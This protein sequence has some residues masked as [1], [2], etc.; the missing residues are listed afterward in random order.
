MFDR[1]TF[2]GNT[3]FNQV[4]FSKNAMFDRATFSGGADFDRATFS[5]NARFDQA[6]FS[7]PARFNDV[8]FSGDATFDIVTFTNDARFNRAIFS[9]NVR[10]D[11][12]TFTGDATFVQA[13]FASDSRFYRATFSGK[14]RFNKASFTGNTRFD[15]VTFINDA[16]FGQTTFSGNATF[17]QATFGRL[18]VFSDAKFE[19]ARQF[20]PLLAYRGLILD[21]AEF[22]EPVQIEVSS[23]AVRCR[24]ARFPH[25]VQFGL[26]W[27]QVVLEE[28]DFPAPSILTGIPRLSTGE[29]ASR[30]EQMIKDWRQ[31]LS[32]EISEQPQLLSLIRA[33][34]A[35]LSLSNVAM[36][37]C[38]FAD[39]H[40]LDKMR[41]EADV[42][43]AIAPSPFG[44]LSRKRRQVIAEERDWRAGR[45]N[46]WAW[47][48]SPWPGALGERPRILDAS[49]IADRYRA[50]RKG[51]ED[52]KNEP[53]A[54]DF[55]YGEM[56]MRRHAPNSSVAERAIIWLYWLIS[57]YGLRALRS[58]I[59]LVVLGVVIMVALT[60][61]GLAAS[62]PVTTPPQQLAGTVSTTPYKSVHINATLS[63]VTPQLPS[64]SQLWTKE[65]TQ[66]ALEVTLESFVF[67]SA[68]QPLTT[69]GTWT[70]I[71]ARILGPVLLALTLLAVRNRV[72]R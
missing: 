56:E 21:G 54:A 18:S 16:T 37:D 30:E 19:Q 2:T 44:R 69:A 51:R 52:A 8:T 72:K 9:G 24:R 67:R 64:A 57:G 40:N 66:T 71:A 10:F 7:R 50:L 49:Q 5:G 60:G 43:F 42:S 29:L 68:D 26:R 13:N 36:A 46:R 33:N 15:K 6:T 53:G 61:W 11:R 58:L 41:L 45:P 14:A 35:G 55:Y 23:I 4:T 20:G 31:F 38:R 63:G 1:A 70:T 22:V 48:P 3:R 62:A 27:A 34:V 59:A 12:A 28:A 32:E 39:A 47:R 17:S 65:R 25:G